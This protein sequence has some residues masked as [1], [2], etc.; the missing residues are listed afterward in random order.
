[1]SSYSLTH[2][3]DQTLL[4]DLAALVTQDRATTAALLAHL[5]EVDS[6]KLYLG[7]AYPSMYMYCVR[8]LRMSEGTAFKRIRAARAARR[9]P[10]IFVALAAGR[11]HVSAI[12]LL[13]AY[14]TPKNAE[15]L[16]AAATHKSKAEIEMLLAERFPRPEVPA[17]IRALGPAATIGELATWPVDQ[18]TSQ[19]GSE[20][21]P[22]PVG[23]RTDVLAPRPA[24]PRM[25]HVATQ[26]APERVRELTAQLALEPVDERVAQLS[27]WTVEESPEHGT[28][29]QIES[30][31]P[32]ATLMPLSPGKFELRLTIDRE[33]REQLL[34]A[35]AL[36]GHAVPSGG[37]A[38]VLKRAV[39]ALVRELEKNKFAKCVRTSV[40]R[41]QPRD[42]SHE[43]NS[44]HIPAHIRRAVWQRDG[45]QCTFVSPT[46]R[47]CEER[48][49]LEFDHTQPLGRGGQTTAGQLQ[50]KCR[51][52]NQFAAECAYGTE[53][54]RRKR[55]AAKRRASRTAAQIDSRSDAQPHPS[56]G[57]HGSPESDNNSRAVAR[58]DVAPWLRQLGFSAD[59]ARRGASQC[60]HMQDAPLDQRVRL[61]LQCLAPQCVRRTAHAASSSA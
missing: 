44:R 14:L 42:K 7:L 46:G 21:A 5:T 20:L 52:H 4:H 58:E 59:E 48:T 55:E 49:R 24:D 23:G 61:A 18:R 1:M 10:A 2:L 57:G 56:A 13:A 45:G 6:R 53:F 35:Q 31:A 8:E 11:L 25:P 43:N 19:L 60:A 47:R 17:S 22:G 30:P 26:L 39:D 38:Q 54:M 36:L 33:T 51:A 41:Q 15:E 16:L 28:S 37:M 34:Y 29:V 9:F 32:R 12:V 50:L 40:S 27:T 3:A